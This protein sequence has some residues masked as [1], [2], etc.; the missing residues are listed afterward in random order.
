ME[1]KQRGWIGLSRVFLSPQNSSEA[2]GRALLPPSLVS[3]LPPSLV[4]GILGCGASRIEELRLYAGRVSVVCDRGEYFPTGVILSEGEPEELL[5]RF[6]AGSVYAFRDQL[7]SGFLP[8]GEGIRIG[9]AG[10]GIRDGGR[11][12]GV[13]EVTSLIIRIP[14]RHSCDVSPLLSLLGRDSSRGFL[15][16]SPPRV[17]KT[18]LLRALAISASGG[19]HPRPTVVVD[20]RGEFA[21]TLPGENLLLSVLVGYPR[22]LG[23]ELAVRSLSPSLILCDEIGS[24]DD[25]DAILHSAN[26][27]V[28]LVASAHAESVSELLSRPALRRLHEA[29]VFSS[30]I[31]L[32]RSE[33]DGFHYRFTPWEAVG[34]RETAPSGK[35]V[36][37]V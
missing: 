26:C 32:S 4:A 19:A 17:G 29:H 37:P 15:V 2:V 36:P 1:Q 20:S 22:A 31:A 5:K 7:A 25:A 34:S 21:G 33:K 23:I 9:I 27:G 12:L 13:H 11:I 10:T 24:P 6:C 3:L 8:L 14:H 18:T 28:P 16:F 30:Y 35:D